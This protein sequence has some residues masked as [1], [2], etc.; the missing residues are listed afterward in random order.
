MLQT[1]R[2]GCT[3]ALIHSSSYIHTYMHTNIHSSTLT[4]YKRTQAS[5]TSQALRLK[6]GSW[7][8]NVKNALFPIEG[9]EMPKFFSMSCMM[10][11]I[12]YIYTTVRDTKDTL[13]VSACGAES[14]TFLKVC[15]SL[16]QCAHAHT[17]IFII[18]CARARPHV[19]VCTYAHTHTG[20]RVTPL[21]TH[22]HHVLTHRT[23]TRT[24]THTH[25]CTECCQR[26][27]CSWCCIPRCRPSSRRTSCST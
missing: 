6:G 17:H 25:R 14:I 11:M 26:R 7:L 5:E 23:H 9:W 19:C 10:F 21:L 8:E 12:I 24:H 4:R 20:T 15:R 18:I 1:L 3:C 13:V 2:W 22:A 27:R 16:L